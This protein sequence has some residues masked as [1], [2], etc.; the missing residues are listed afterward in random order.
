MTRRWIPLLTASM[1]ALAA[2]GGGDDDSGSTDADSTGGSGELREVTVGML[3]ILPTAALYAGIEEGFFED[4]GLEVTVETGQGGAA[5]LPA[6]MAGQIDFATSNPVSLLQARGED[7]DVR[8]IA[9]WTSALS[10]GETDINGVVAAAGS[11]VESAADLAG[12]TVAVN[13]L[14]GMGGLT[15][16]EAVRADGGDPD[17]VSFVEMPFPDMPAALSGGNVDA[18]WVPEPFLGGLQAAGNVVATYSS[19]ESVPGHPTQLFFTS[20]QLLQSDPELV[21]DFTAAIEET[22]EFADE[23]PDAV[24]AQ[25]PQ[26]L[27]QL[28]P[29]ALENVQLEE[30]GTD[31]RREQLEQL[32]ELM[33]ED[34]LLE[35]DADVDG[36]LPEE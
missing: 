34:G 11:G 18:V 32:G 13:T 35:D 26:V 12:K 31:L 8:V 15:I 5:L 20:P 4:H 19:R 30:F 25:V 27:P 29:E 16:R 21:E 10:E 36:L 23:N 7:L 6:V 14:N 24:K 3:P 22:L 28:P 2:C 9:H 17:A 1:L 33:V